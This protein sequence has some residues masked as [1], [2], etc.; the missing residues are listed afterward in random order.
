MFVNAL[1][2]RVEASGPEARHSEADQRHEQAQQVEADR[3]P[4]LVVVPVS[5]DRGVPA[6]ERREQM[7]YE[8][9]QPPRGVPQQEDGPDQYGGQRG[10]SPPGPPDEPFAALALRFGEPG[11]QLAIVFQE[12]LGLGHHLLVLHVERRV[13]LVELGHARVPCAERP[14]VAAFSD[15]LVEAGLILRSH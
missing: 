11:W 8:E 12:A 3:H 14:A 5:G 15:E 10:L 13:V 7:R 9:H 4:T 1:D 6:P 2:A